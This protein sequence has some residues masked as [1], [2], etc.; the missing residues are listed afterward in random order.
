MMVSNGAG[1]RKT[2]Y[3]GGPIP[4]NVTKDLSPFNKKNLRYM[5]VTFL[6]L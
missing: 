4:T 2:S 3:N 1:T 6:S 5:V